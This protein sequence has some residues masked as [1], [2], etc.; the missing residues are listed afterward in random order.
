MR[1]KVTSIILAICL[2]FWGAISAS[3][4]DADAD[5]EDTTEE[6]TVQAYRA[7]NVR[8]APSVGSSILAQLNPGD[9]APVLARSSEGSDWLL[10]QVDDQQGWVAF[11]VVVVSGDLST[12][13][14][15]EVELTPEASA[16]ILDEDAALALA[17]SGV[18]AIAF[19][20]AN[21]RLL[22]S[23]NSEVVTILER[24]TVA[25]VLA[26]SD[27]DNGWVQVETEQGVGWVAYYLVTINGDLDDLPIIEHEPIPAPTATPA[28][29]NALTVAARYNI[30]LRTEPTLASDTIMVV[31][32]ESEIIADGRDEDARWIRVSYEDQVGWLLAAL[33]TT[34]DD[35][36]FSALPVVN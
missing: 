8:S 6:V 15:E 34:Q 27:E 16:D 12:L 18:S 7:V 25:P 36:D 2:M 28:L 17:P 3:A 20:R 33:V 10:I 22:P 35:V 4:Q 9:N 29:V 24:G 23:T 1:V 30:N 14:I 32:F 21:V 26:R 13:P 11:F 19:R 31:P 5:T